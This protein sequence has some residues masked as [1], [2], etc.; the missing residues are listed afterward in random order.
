MLFVFQPDL[1]SNIFKHHLQLGHND[2]A[3][4]ALI[5]NPNPVR[6]VNNCQRE[7]YPDWPAYVFLSSSFENLV[8]KVKQGLRLI[9][10]VG[11]GV[12]LIISQLIGFV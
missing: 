4:D 10:G 7:N 2:L 9:A 8:F 5:T 11:L 6:L 3:Y 12:Q 1:W